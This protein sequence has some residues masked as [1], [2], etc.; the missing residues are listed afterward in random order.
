MGR[1]VPSEAR[2]AYSCLLYSHRKKGWLLLIL[3]LQCSGAAIAA[4]YVSYLPLLNWKPSEGRAVSSRT[5]LLS[6]TRTGVQRACGRD[7]SHRLPAAPRPRPAPPP[8]S[9]QTPPHAGC[10]PPSGR[11]KSPAARPCPRGAFSGT[12]APPPLRSGPGP[13]LRIPNVP[14]DRHISSK[15]PRS[16]F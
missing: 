3:F 10:F 8:A 9:L 13:H 1:R 4:T 16:G 15:R 12:P 6:A 11:R 14:P 5:G 2:S 7:P